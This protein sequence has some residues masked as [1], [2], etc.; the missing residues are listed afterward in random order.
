MEKIDRILS[1]IQESLKWVGESYCSFNMKCN[2]MTAKVVRWL[3]SV[4]ATGS[5]TEHMSVNP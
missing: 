3:G 5:R 2:Y 1:L 4:I